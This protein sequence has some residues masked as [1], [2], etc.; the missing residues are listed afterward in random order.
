MVVQM[1]NNNKT[2][3]QELV[4]DPWAKSGL[5]DGKRDEEY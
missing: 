5:G 2:M 4:E 1:N 3:M